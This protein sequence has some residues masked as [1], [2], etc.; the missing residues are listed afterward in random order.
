MPRA[1]RSRHLDA[2]LMARAQPLVWFTGSAIFLLVVLTGGVNPDVTV[3]FLAIDA[4]GWAMAVTMFLGRDRLP[5]WFEEFSQYVGIA[6]V[7]AIVA[8]DGD[9]TSFFALFYLWLAVQATYFAPWRRAIGQGAVMALGY[10]I[11]IAIAADGAFPFVRWLMLVSTAFVIGALVAYMRDRNLTLMRQLNL[12]AETDELTGLGNRRLLLT[13]LEAAI[14]AATPEDPR[15]LALFDLDGFKTYN[16]L[17]GHPAGDA[18]LRR[19]GITLSDA[20]QPAGDAYR[21]GGDEF[22]VLAAVDAAGAGPVVAGGRAALTAEGEGFEVGASSGSVMLPAE[23]DNVSDAL[24]TADQRMYASK[25]S[26]AGASQ[27]QARDLLLRVLDAREPALRDRQEGVSQRAAELGR[28]LGM[29][30]EELDVLVR[31]AELH[32]IGKIGLPEGVLEKPGPLDQLERELVETHTLIGQ[33]I[34]GA[35]PAMAPVAKLVRSSHERWDGDG[36]PDGL[37]GEDIPLAA[38]VIFVCDAFEA[39]TSERPYRKTY[40]TA[41][42]LDELRAGAGSQFDP[43]VV[44]RFCELI[45]ESPDVPTHSPN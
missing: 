34:L 1:V 17:Y 35:A 45:V 24:R 22:C 27:R 11:A 2:E 36:Y 20:V 16:D 31:A 19:L 5:D 10:A 6:I 18:L 7:S 30:S 42:A 29:D 23:A 9:E 25:G 43:E 33:R 3:P 44:D 41:S 13:D 32:D 37:S 12:A 4:L 26:R 39:M 21:L 15:M 14:E 38:R 40:D 8:L 28:R